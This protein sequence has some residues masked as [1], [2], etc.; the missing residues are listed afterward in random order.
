M[1]SNNMAAVASVDD[2]GIEN[3]IL[4][5]EN[6][7]RAVTGAEPPAAA[8]A[9]APIP[10]EKDPARFVEEQLDRLLALLEQPGLGTTATWSPLL[11]VLEND[12][13]LTVL[14]DVPG[15]EHKDAEVVLAG[16]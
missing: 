9:H 14:V 13:E 5:V 7:Y 4:G 6:L 10:V 3:A 11:S 12:N 16:T 15:V 8:D 2:S 1:P